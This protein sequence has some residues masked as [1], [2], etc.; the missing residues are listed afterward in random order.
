MRAIFGLLDPRWASERIGT[1]GSAG[2][3]AKKGLMSAEKNGHDP[4]AKEKVHVTHVCLNVEC[5][6]VI[7]LFFISLNKIIE[8]HYAFY[9][10]AP[11]LLKEKSFHLPCEKGPC[12]ETKE[13]WIGFHSTS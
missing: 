10:N 1:L 12:E 7:F 4:P 8:V 3:G 5:I 11:R 2:G 6:C 13:G 9:N